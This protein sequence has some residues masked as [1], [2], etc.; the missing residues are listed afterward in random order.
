M[1]LI[2]IQIFG[3]TVIA[4]QEIKRWFQHHHD[5][6]EE[7]KRRWEATSA[8]RLYELGRQ[9]LPSYRCV[10]DEYPVLRTTEGYQLVKLDFQQKF[11]EK[12]DLLF[13]RF[14]D[15]RS[16]AQAVFANEVSPQGKPLCEFLLHDDLT[17]G[18]ATYY[19]VLKVI[20]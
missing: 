7:L 14:V 10:L 6:W 18:K 9:D 20:Q 4:Y 1:F 2:T 5:E 13:S 17:E 3:I 11:P 16:R 19:L 15:F 12:V 8:V